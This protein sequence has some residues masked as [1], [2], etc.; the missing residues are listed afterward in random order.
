[1][2]ITSKGGAS[3]KVMRLLGEARLSRDDDDSLSIEVQDDK[4]TYTAKA[5]G[6]RLMYMAHDVDVS[7]AVSP[8]DREDLGPWLTEPDKI[9][10]WDAL[11]VA[12]ID[13][14]SRSL[15]DWAKFIEWCDD[16]GKEVISIDEGFDLGKDVGRLVAGILILFAEF[17]RKRIG[18]RRRDTA[19]KMR[20]NGQWNGGTAPYGYMAKVGNGAEGLYQD[21]DA[22]P[23]VRRIV[24]DV[25]D[26]LP[27]KTICERLAS[28]NVP[29]MRGATEWRISAVRRMLM[30]RALR[31]ELQHKSHSVYD[32]DGNPILIT[33]DPLITEPEWGLL[34]EALAARARPYGTYPGTYMLL[35]IAFCGE[36]GSPLYHQHNARNNYYRCPGKHG[37]P[38]IRAEVLQTTVAEE[39]LRVYGH[40]QIERRAA[41]GKDYASELSMV[42]R[43]LEELD[44]A[45][46]GHQIS[47]ERFSKVSK[48]LEARRDELEILVKNAEEARWE[49]TGETV[50]DRW[51]RS[52][53]NGRHMMLR[54]L[55]ITWELRREY[56]ISDHSWRWRFV[57]NW[58]R[59]Q[60]SHERLTRAA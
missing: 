21:P 34:S 14:L 15:L 37:A 10:Q 25:I 35:R 28:E 55:G 16:H 45:Y 11:I 12:K 24:N 38:G 30:S 29:T 50:A 48:T 46:A 7:G 39:L 22:A 19:E 4:I 59:V 58:Q 60:D 56:R 5:R 6:D 43:E 8:F 31:G 18:E 42:G 32:A 9:A 23:I 41:T 20:A 26:G 40:R 1:M 13:R 53:Q 27:I 17:E 33:D 51:E 49:P 57:S 36:C 54:R 3:S 47:I 52:D 2:E 44:A